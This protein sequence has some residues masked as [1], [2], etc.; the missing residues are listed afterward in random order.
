MFSITTIESSTTRP[1]AIV[2]ALRVNRFKLYP[3]TQRP[4]KVTKSDVGMEI[5][6]TRVERIEARNS[7]IIKIANVSP[8]KPSM[9]RFSSCFSTKGP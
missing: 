6:V 1:T 3:E 4:M 5:A 9:V 8:S 7:K 2:R